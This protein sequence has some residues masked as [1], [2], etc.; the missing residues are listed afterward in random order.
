MDSTRCYGQRGKAAA[1]RG[2]ALLLAL[3]AGGCSNDNDPSGTYKGTYADGSQETI[4]I[5]PDG[6]YEQTLMSGS[7]IIYKNRGSWSMRD[8]YLDFDNFISAF[9]LPRRCGGKTE[10]FASATGGWDNWTNEL[11]FS[12]FDNYWLKRVSK[13]I[14]P[15]EPM[16]DAEVRQYRKKFT[17]EG[18]AT[19]KLTD[20]GLK[21]LK[22][23]KGLRVLDLR[24]TPITDA[25]LKD[26]KELKDLEA[27]YLDGTQITDAGLKDLKELKDLRS[28][29]LNGAQITDAG[30]KD[31]K[32]FT[33][34]K[35]LWL[36]N[37]QIT[38]AGLK[39]LKE[40]KGLQGL[41]L[42][43]TRI[44]DAGLKDLKEL[45]NLQGLN[46]GLTKITDAGLKDLKELKSLDT[47]ILTWTQ[48]T[49][50]GLKDLKEFKGLK[51]LNLSD[52]KITNTGLEDL[53]QALPKTDIYR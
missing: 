17:D 45:K 3:L 20:A 11:S 22:K 24:D 18:S 49:D 36:R 40:L 30:L 8:Y 19:R 4:I 42:G 1:A 10:F 32:E 12:E 38:D 27:L 23:L 7:Q 37:T 5:R 53:R 50:A 35:S 41:D 15:P 44:T 26:L 33:D 13:I 47:L 34:L 2:V 6:F 52:T 28:L 51:R 14:P 43:G 9:G 46:L 31:L 39:D 21:D 16:D 48:I 29:W 25:D